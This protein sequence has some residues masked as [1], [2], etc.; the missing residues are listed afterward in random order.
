MAGLLTLARSAF[1]RISGF[2]SP[3]PSLF[4]LSPLN[5]IDDF[6]IV[7]ILLRLLPTK[8]ARND[9]DKLRL[10]DSTSS[11]KESDHGLYYL[12]SFARFLE[13]R[14]DRQTDRQTEL[15]CDRRSSIHHIWNRC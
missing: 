11:R 6:V 7:I 2:Y 10:V 1:M 14:T 3:P 9:D 5:E 12:T 4:F 8:V 15:E 13:L